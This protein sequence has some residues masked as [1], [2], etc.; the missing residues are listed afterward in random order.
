MLG[1]YPR[2]LLDKVQGPILLIDSEA[3]IYFANMRAQQL[4]YLDD[5]VTH[6]PAS[7][8]TWQSE[9][10][11]G[12]E[13][14][15]F[16]PNSRIETIASFEGPNNDPTQFHVVISSFEDEYMLVT[17]LPVSQQVVEVAASPQSVA[18]ALVPEVVEPAVVD[19]EPQSLQRYQLARDVDGMP[20]FWEA[21]PHAIYIIR[22]DYKLVK[23]NRN[24]RKSQ[25]QMEA[26]T[27]YEFLGKSQ[28][29]DN[30]P[31]RYGFKATWTQ[32][33]GH[34]LEDKH[35]TE[36]F[37]PYPGGDG[38]IVTFEDHTKRVQ[39][40][41]TIKEERAKVT[42]NTSLQARQI[43]VMQ[44][45]HQEQ[46]NLK[47]AESFLQALQY[48]FRPASVMILLE[49]GEERRKIVIKPH[50][51]ADTLVVDVLAQEY[52]RIAVK[53]AEPFTLDA[54]QTPW[55]ES[56][57]TQC[58]IVVNKEQL[59][60]LIM[61][62]GQIDPNVLQLYIR[63]FASNW[64]NRTL[65]RK[66]KHMA[67]TDQLTGLYNRAY[68]DMQFA[69]VKAAGYECAVILIDVNGLKQVNDEF[70]HHAGDSLICAM[71]K[72][73]KSIISLPELP[74]R[75]GGDEFVVLL[76]G[77][78]T[79]TAQ[80]RIEALKAEIALRHFTAGQG[81]RKQFSAS[82]GAAG[83]EE[84]PLHRL[85]RNADQRMYADKQQHYAA[86]KNAG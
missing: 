41:Q 33:F 4:L 49:L 58:P 45:L 29:C 34:T 10:P 35:I 15:L 46:D 63:P 51:N 13:R 30:C 73:L 78:D 2:A 74:A 76:P 38:A 6:L 16:E 57:L 86:T 82:F 77:A 62:G 48:E 68:F 3:K 17:L 21:F 80:G 31:A 75:L 85:M 22:N 60:L 61:H 26:Q 69:K 12:F 20:L 65:L 18:Q 70:G 8:L 71:A 54:A 28:P 32:T 9:D 19:N 52:R 55:K 47:A 27:C 5:S 64:L 83:S 66:T 50:L 37:I 36:T 81:G 44:Y 53:Q 40:I 23:A 84:F 24:G 7:F 56:Q 25:R 1:E 72:V 14:V 67:T 79:A 39:L 42:A 59:G 43:K 11:N